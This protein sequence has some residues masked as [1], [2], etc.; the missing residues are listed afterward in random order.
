MNGTMRRNILCALSF[1]FQANLLL[2]FEII[3]IVRD[4][5]EDQLIALALLSNDV[6]FLR[7]RREHRVPAFRSAS[8]VCAW[9]TSVEDTGDSRQLVKSST[10]QHPRSRARIYFVFAYLTELRATP[11]GLRYYNT[12]DCTVIIYTLVSISVDDS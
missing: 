5:I 9:L 2:L 12:P 6:T 8:R 10:G 3:I 4:R 7:K 11:A 1:L